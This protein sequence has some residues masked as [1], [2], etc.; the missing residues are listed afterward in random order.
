VPETRHRRLRR[1]AAVALLPFFAL[2]AA[3][4]SDGD[5]LAADA[6]DDD[7]EAPGGSVAPVANQDHWHAAFGIYVCDSFVEAPVDEGP[8]INGIHTHGDGLVHIHPFIET[9]GGAGAVMD[10][11][12]EQIGLELDDG[13]LGL[14]DGTTY[15]DGDG[16]P[17]GPGRV[18][19]FVWGA[20]APEGSAPEVVTT[21]IG[22]TRFLA[23]HQR[24]VLAFAPDGV[25]P[26]QPPST[27]TLER[28]SDVE[29][30]QEPVAEAS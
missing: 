30:P 18:S 15:T 21:D 19:L 4:S 10:V 25:V 17:Q 13:R 5:G 28:P 24:F 27:P 22:S 12:A 6:T 26:P 1:S 14:P 29:A 11:F 3:C 9:A 7:V 16:C 23:D 2:V 8:D 20:D